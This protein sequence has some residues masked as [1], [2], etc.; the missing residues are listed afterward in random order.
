MMEI[1]PVQNFPFSG[2]RLL[3]KE[4]CSCYSDDQVE[5]SLFVPLYSGKQNKGLILVI[6][7]LPIFF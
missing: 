7:F 2:R 5:V 3:Q 6:L 4:N 1:C